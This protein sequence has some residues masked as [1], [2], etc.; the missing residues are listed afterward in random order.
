MNSNESDIN[1][2]IN[3]LSIDYLKHIESIVTKELSEKSAVYYRQQIIRRLKRDDNKNQSLICGQN[4]CIRC[5][6]HIKKWRIKPKTKTKKKSNKVIGN[7]LICHNINRIDGI[8]RQTKKKETKSSTKT[9]KVEKKGLKTKRDSFQ[10]PINKTPN[11]SN[12][13]PINR[14]SDKQKH[15]IQNLLS[16]NKKRKVDQKTGLFDFLQICS[17]K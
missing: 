3:N 16:S 13:T 10:T 5:L 1:C 14:N 9:P 6:S 2:V 8:K 11:N 12:K 7:C 17:Q 15:I 4:H